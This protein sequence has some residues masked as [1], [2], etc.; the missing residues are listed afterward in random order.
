MF[1][2]GVTLKEVPAKILREA[3]AEARAMA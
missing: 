1:E 3:T 2:F